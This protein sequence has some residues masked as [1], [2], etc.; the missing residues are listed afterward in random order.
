MGRW[1]TLLVNYI[2]DAG[3]VGYGDQARRMVEALKAYEICHR[4]HLI[5]EALP[6]CFSRNQASCLTKCTTAKLEPPAMMK[7]DFAGSGMGMRLR[8]GENSWDLGFMSWGKALDEIVKTVDSAIFDLTFDPQGRNFARK[9]STL[10]LR[11]QEIMST[12]NGAISASPGATNRS[13]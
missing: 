5:C 6:T 11:G 1:L 13:G 7:C 3:M 10:F 4:A 8:A 9:G 12:E 2:S